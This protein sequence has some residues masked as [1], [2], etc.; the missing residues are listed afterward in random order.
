MLSSVANRTYWA[1]RYLERAENTARLLNVY[2]NLLLDLP[3]SAGASWTHMIRI[4]GCSEQFGQARRWPLERSAV[5]FMT[6]DLDNPSAI[7]SSIRSARENVRTLRDLVPMEA[8]EAINELYIF[9]NRRMRFTTNRRVRFAIL[10]DI[11]SRCQQ[12]TG[13]IQG[14]MS[15]G[16][17]YQFMRLGRNLER[18]DM[19]TRILDVAGDLLVTDSESVSEFDT[20]LWVN[21]LRTL[22]AYQAYRQSVR[23]RIAPVRVLFFLIG[24]VKFPRSV[25]HCV[26]E[27]RA[28]VLQLPANQPVLSSIDQLE[29]SIAELSLR[30][31]AR[32][33]LHQSMDDVQR[34][35]GTVHE[36]IVTTWFTPS[37]HE[38]RSYQ[39]QA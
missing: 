14:T 36:A 37:R 11:V 3:N 38:Q 31:L 24:D 26:N 6:S 12:I 27:L 13:L 32:E 33:Q 1:A 25:S 22:S 30:E 35:L 16:D 5:R 4:A 39:A 23:S 19:T 2:T 15:H 29:A 18:A 10:S 21:V 20:T 8:F 28:S 9:A 7:Q 17:A 34:L